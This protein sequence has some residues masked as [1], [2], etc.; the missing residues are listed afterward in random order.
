M[1]LKTLNTPDPNS[2]HI[3]IIPVKII[4]SINGTIETSFLIGEIHPAKNDMVMD[5]LCVCVYVCVFVRHSV[6]ISILAS[7]PPIDHCLVVTY[8]RYP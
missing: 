5:N 2:L 3:V 4:E 7:P 6:T 8:P 1:M